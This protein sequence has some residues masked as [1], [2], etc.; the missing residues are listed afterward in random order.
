[1]AIWTDSKTYLHA[2]ISIVDGAISLVVLD[3]DKF[4]RFGKGSWMSLAAGQP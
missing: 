3:A 4:N 1:M 2:V